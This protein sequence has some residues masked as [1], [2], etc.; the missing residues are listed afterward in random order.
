MTGGLEFSL[1]VGWPDIFKHRV[2]FDIEGLEFEVMCDGGGRNQGIRYFN[3]MRPAE[4][5]NPSSPHFSRLRGLGHAR[6]DR[7]PRSV[8]G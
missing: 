6:H 5:P 4:L 8:A 7:Q 1:V 3:A 2:V